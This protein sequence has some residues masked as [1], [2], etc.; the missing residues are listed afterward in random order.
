MAEDENKLLDHEYDGIREEDNRMPGWWRILFALSI[1]WAVGYMLYY[2]V[3]D[4]GYSQIDEYKK[5]LNPYYVKVRSADARLLGVLPEYRSPYYNPGEMTPRMKAL[6]S[7]K[8][9]ARILMTREN[10]TLTY[11]AVTDPARVEQGGEIYQANCAQCHGKLG[12]G[13]VGPNL[14]DDY[15][16]HPH[17]FTGIVKSVK[18]GY[19]AQ[20]MVPWQ[21]TLS[22]DNILNVSAY[23]QT[24]HGTN[25]PNPKVPQGEL[26]TGESSP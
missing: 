10:D 4:I 23:V 21:G 3:F 11:V 24:L 15:W 26:V 20:G 2:H 14:T 12:E 7:Q 19:P 9:G 18:Y 5:E 8:G 13:G 6:M 16:L 1:V 17:D 22:E 25:P